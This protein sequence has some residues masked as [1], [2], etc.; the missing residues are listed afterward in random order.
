MKRAARLSR[1]S[2]NVNPDLLK[3]LQSFISRE[4]LDEK[5][6]NSLTNDLL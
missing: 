6:K 3:N 2:M 5:D 1:F 4:T